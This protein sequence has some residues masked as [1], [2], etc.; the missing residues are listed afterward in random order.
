MLFTR[1][2]LIF[3]NSISWHSQEVEG[4]RFGG[5]RIPSLHFADHVGFLGFCLHCLG[6]RN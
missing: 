1:I 5:V 6:M 4:V 2:L 3:S